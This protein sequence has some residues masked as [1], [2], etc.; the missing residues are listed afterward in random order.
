MWTIITVSNIQQCDCFAKH[1]FVLFQVSKRYEE[2]ERSGE[3][4]S[5]FKRIEDKSKMKAGQQQQQQD[6]GKSNRGRRRNRDALEEE[7]EDAVENG[8]VF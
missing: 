4:H 3:L 2:K 5:E 1:F 7:D 6:E 8:E